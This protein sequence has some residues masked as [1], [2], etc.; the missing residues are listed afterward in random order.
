VTCTPGHDDADGDG[1]R[2]GVGEVLE[3]DGAY[4]DGQEEQLLRGRHRL[5]PKPTGQDEDDDGDGNG[6]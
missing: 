5:T 4:D 3:P 1:V 2:L 6:D